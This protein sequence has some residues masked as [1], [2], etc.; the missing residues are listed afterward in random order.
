M[1]PKHKRYY[2]MVTAIIP[3]MAGIILFDWIALP[4]WA[5][6]GGFLLCLLIAAIG[7]QSRISTLYITVALVL[8]GG[9]MVSLRGFH[10]QVP[11]D[12][13]LYLTLEV[14]DNPINRKGFTYMPARITG[15]ELNDTYFT[16]NE[17]V[18]LYL[19]TLIKVDFGTRIEAL[20]RIVPFPEKFGSYGKLMSRRGFG[21]TIFIRAEDVINIEN[22]KIRN[23]HTIAVERLALLGLSGDE[24]AVVGAMSISD[25]RG[26]T[27]EL[28]QAYARSGASHI[29][30]VSGLHVGIIFMLVNL[31]I[32]W[33]VYIWRGHI[34]K[35]WAVIIPIWIYAALCGF[36]PSVVRA[37]IMFTAMQ[38]AIVTDSRYISLNILAFTA[39]I[40]LIYKP[41]YLFDTSFQLS[42]IA[43]VAIMIWG[44]PIMRPLRSKRL[45]V[46]A[47]S[48]TAV[49][50]IVSSIATM[51]LIAYTFGTVSIVGFLL[52][53]I[54]ILF[55]YAIVILAVIWIAIPIPSL[56]GIFG[57]LLSALS[58]GL[59]YI[60]EGV[61]SWRW[62]AVEL[63]IPEWAVWTIYAV[64]IA[65]TILLNNIKPKK[66][67]NLPL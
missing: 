12:E 32:I 40:M 65:I 54:V 36:S 61:A 38:I 56:A 47:L 44:L 42:F 53:P 48:T 58:S 28:R 3:F 57:T 26:M 31:L 39:F 41:D 50:G 35:A 11:Q 30:A 63:S 66:T 8:F 60:I 17:R 51:P 1:P 13:R 10:P 34:V 2:P 9:A 19:D 59:N 27:S 64:A 21:G 37:A 18:Q 33:I 43:V 67:V 22:I 24:A 23:L 15:Y 45:W 29:L 52:N 7:V 20:G 62:S 4:A 6:W 16:A 14:E 25:R 55:A 5:L 46:D 49:V